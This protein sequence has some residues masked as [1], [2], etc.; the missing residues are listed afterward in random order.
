LITASFAGDTHKLAV[1]V[2]APTIVQWPALALGVF[3][4]TRIPTLLAPALAAL[5]PSTD[6][7]ATPRA[8]GRWMFDIGVRPW[9]VM[10]VGGACGTRHI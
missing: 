4:M 6:N 3:A 7:L 2:G 1:E 5:A 9:F 10:L 8:R